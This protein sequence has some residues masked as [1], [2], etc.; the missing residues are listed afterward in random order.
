[1]SNTVS[2]ISRT[3]LKME[4]LDTNHVKI[5]GNF[6]FHFP[7]EPTKR[8]YLRNQSQCPGILETSYDISSKY[9]NAP[10]L[11]PPLAQKNKNKKERRAEK[12]EE[13]VT[14]Q[15]AGQSERKQSSSLRGM[16]IPAAPIIIRIRPSSPDLSLVSASDSDRYL[17][18]LCSRSKRNEKEEYGRSSGQAYTAAAG[19]RSQTARNPLFSRPTSRRSL[20][21]SR[22]NTGEDSRTNEISPPLDRPR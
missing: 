18:D 16:E 12:E 9:P 22:A 14:R 17:R 11:V 1:M 13:K 3:R 2:L 6:Q 5:F 21:L 8:S 19:V 7:W 10:A 15:R 4:E 20:V